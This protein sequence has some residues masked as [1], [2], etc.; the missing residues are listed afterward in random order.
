MSHFNKDDIAHTLG[1]I[2]GKL[3]SFMK[4]VEAL[5]KRLER[6]EEATSSLN[7]RTIDL[8]NETKNYTQNEISKLK[9]TQAKFGVYGMLFLTLFTASLSSIIPSIL[10][11][12]FL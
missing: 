11:K 1:S 12:L 4:T 6:S 5:D 2:E 10:K 3:D 8:H 9:I 7:Q